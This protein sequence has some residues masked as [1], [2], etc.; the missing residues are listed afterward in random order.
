MGSVRA[1]GC[2]CGCGLLGHDNRDGIIEYALP[3]DE[4]VEGRVDIQ[5]VEDGQGGH[6]V[7]GRYQRTKGKAISVCVCVCVC[8]KIPIVVANIHSYIVDNFIIV[9]VYIQCMCHMYMYALPKV[10]S[11]TSTLH[12]DDMMKVLSCRQLC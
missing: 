12:H 9:P 2:G 8:V 10:T 11:L 5:G 3:K 1:S 4:H 7:N 6:R